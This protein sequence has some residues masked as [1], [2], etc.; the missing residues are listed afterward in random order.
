MS[1]DSKAIARL[2]NS[3]V[4]NDIANGDFSYAEKI[5][6][7]YFDHPN[8]ITLNNL[9]SEAFKYLREHYQNEYYY[10]SMIIQKIFMRHHSLEKATLLSEFR[11]G[12]NKADCVILNG[13]SV[14]YEIKTDYDSLSR[15]K[16]QLDSYLQVFDEVYV[17]C[18]EKHRKSVLE[19]APASVGILLLTESQNFIKARKAEIRKLPLNKTLLMQSLRQHEYKELAE[20]IASEEIN[21]PN[22]LI[23]NKC[24][25]IVANCENDVFINKKIITILKKTRK[26]DGKLIKKLPDSLANAVISYRFRKR[27]IDTLVRFFQESEG[28]YVLSSS[29]REAI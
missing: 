28:L 29:T 9:Y 15:L 20:A 11:V 4:L 1:W 22:T 12:S 18:S 16:D 26:N 7:Q 5:T 10:K 25:S 27:E 14:C 8:E 17:V 19:L 21:V 6:G 23:Y 24:L 3:N 13:K 2:F